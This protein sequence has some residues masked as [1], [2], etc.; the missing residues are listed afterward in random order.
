M[1][2]YEC[3]RI[4]I[5]LER[6][7]TTSGM[8]DEGLYCYNLHDR[9]GSQWIHE[10]SLKIIVEK[11]K[12]HKFESFAIIIQNDATNIRTTNQTVAKVMIETLI[13][14]YRDDANEIFQNWYNSN[15][16]SEP[17]EKNSK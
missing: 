10:F 17:L 7:F 12:E 6:Y 4:I 3:E 5:F 16:W 8:L 15:H 14:V 11:A 13:S 9:T 2:K 1:T